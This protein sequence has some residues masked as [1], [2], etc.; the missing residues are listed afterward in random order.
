MNRRP[1][2]LALLLFLLLAVVHTWPLASDPA[3][4]SRDDNADAVLNEWTIAWVAHET[5]RDPLHLFDANIFYPDRNVLAYSEHMFVPSMM[6]APMLWSGAS[7]VLTYN[8]LLL[9]GLALTGWSM[10]FVI[11]RWTGDWPAGILAGVLVAF[12][13]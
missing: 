3:H 6:G 13:A 2:W 5:P 7:P 1:S 10:A 11:V 4:L 12:N 9:A 8:L